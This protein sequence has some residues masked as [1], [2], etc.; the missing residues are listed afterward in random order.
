MRRRLML[1]LL[2][3]GFVTPVWAG[4]ALSTDNRSLFFGLM[5]LGETKELAQFGSYHNQ[6]TCSST[7][8]RLW[9]LKVQL[10]QPLSAG[11]EAIPV[12][13]FQ[14]QM[15]YTN[16]TGT[17]ANPFQY[18]PFRL[19]PALI[20]TSGANEAAGASI[21]LQFKYSLKIPDAQISGAYQTT[22]RFTLT[23]VL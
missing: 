19:T 12:E 6:L 3:M 15:S 16:G 8:N 21:K 17:V 2:V 1:M 9:Y 18:T 11:D 4:L 13:N 14:W 10:L 23:E 5:Q 20:Y 7:N 22:I